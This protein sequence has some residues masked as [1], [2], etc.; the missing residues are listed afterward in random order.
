MKS[1][2]SFYVFTKWK[3][4]QEYA[5]GSKNR[6]SLVPVE[7][8]KAYNAIY[9]ELVT[10]AESARIAS[11]AAD[12]LILKT[13]NFSPKYGSRGHGP[14]DLWV[15]LCASNSEP[16][17]QMPQ[18]Y[19]IASHRGLEV[20]FAVSINEDDYYDGDAKA[21]N[22]NVVPI[23][24]GKLPDPTEPLVANLE[25]AILQQGDWH[26]NTKTRLAPGDF[27]FDNY[28]SLSAMLAAL[29]TTTNLR[30]G[31]T[32]CRVFSGA[33]IENVDIAVEFILALQNFLPLISRCAPNS[34][35]IEIVGNKDAVSDCVDDNPFDPTNTADARKRVF[36][37]VAQ[38]QGQ[39]AFRQ[40]L[41]AAYQRSMRYF[42]DVSARCVGSSSHHAIPRP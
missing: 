38:R 29:K 24:N 19:A 9:D 18:V 33:Q 2:S 17:G 37:A 8:K 6:A 40:A 12:Q 10:A 14:N 31:G 15:S 36:A 5:F 32:V 39:K 3:N 20:G 22:R 42:G 21:R 7:D 16:L 11:G 26:F 28:G 13:M 4:A 1:S 25:G 23:I 34:W 35:D 30:G 27:G 41:I